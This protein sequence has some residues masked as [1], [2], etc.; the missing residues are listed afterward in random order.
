MGIGDGESARGIGA[1]NLLV[2]LLSGAKP[3]PPLVL[4]GS[5]TYPSTSEFSWGTNHLCC[6]TRLCPKHMPGGAPCRHVQG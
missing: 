6:T 1:A 5:G 2:P 4:G 3:G